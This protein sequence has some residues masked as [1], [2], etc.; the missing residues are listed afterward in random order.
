[1]AFEK[2]FEG[3]VIGV[4]VGLVLAV[5]A[6]IY[7]ARKHADERREQIAFFHELVGKMREVCNNTTGLKTEQVE[8]SADQMRHFHISNNVRHLRHT[9]DGR[10]TRLTFDEIY[11]LE[12]AHYSIKMI[13]DQV[14][15]LPKGSDRI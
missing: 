9:I 7:T 13:L 15:S 4:S 6:A 8:F 14:D 11:E 3:V 1:M 5:S 10:S 12:E 2:L